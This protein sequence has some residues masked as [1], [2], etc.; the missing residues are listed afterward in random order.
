VLTR[1]PDYELE[2]G[3]DAVFHGS[4]VTRGY[5]RLPVVFSPGERSGA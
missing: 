1:M 5:R 4:S 2:P 3:N